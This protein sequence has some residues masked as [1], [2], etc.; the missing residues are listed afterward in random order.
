VLEVEGKIL[1]IDKDRV[2]ELPGMKFNGKS[3]IYA[4]YIMTRQTDL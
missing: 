3:D 1:G 4:F 2:L